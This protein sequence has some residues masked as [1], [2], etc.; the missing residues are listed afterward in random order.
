MAAR[1]NR[2]IPLLIVAFILATAAPTFAASTIYV[3]ADAPGAND[4]SSWDDAYNYLQDALANANSALKPVEIRVAEGIYTP[5]SNSANPNGSG[6]RYATFQL[7]NSVALKGGYASAGAPDPNAR[8]IELYETILTGDLNGDD[9][10]PPYLHEKHDNSYHVVT[11]SAT[12]ASAVLDGFTIYGGFAYDSSNKVE[13]GGGMLNENGSPMLKDCTFKWN[14]ASD[15]GG[16]MYNDN[17]KPTLINCKFS[18]NFAYDNNGGGM[19]N[20]KSNPTL[21]NC[22]FSGNDAYWQGGGMCNY[23]SNPTLENCTFTANDVMDVGSGMYN[24][25]SSPTLTNCIFS[26]NLAGWNGGGMRNSYSSPILTNCTFVGN[27]AYTGGGMDN[28]Y[29]T[30][31]LANCTFSGN[32]ADVSSGGMYNYKSSPTLTNCVFV[33]NSGRDC[34]GMCNTD[35]SPRLTNCVFSHNVSPAMYNSKSSDLILTNCTFAQNSGNALACDSYLQ[36]YP[37]KLVLTNCILWN[38]GDEIRNNDNS[39]ITINYSDVQGGWPGD[40]NIDADPC[41]AELGYRDVNVMPD[42]DTYHFW[43]EGDYHLMPDSPCIDAGEPNYIAGP[44]ETDLDGKPRVLDGDN[45][46]VPVV[47]MGAYESP[48]PAEARILP[49]TIN[50]ASKGNWITCYIWLPEGYDV[51]DIEPDSIFLEDEIQPEQFSV[52][53]QKQVATATF[54][55]EKVQSILN[56]GDIEL[57]ITCQLADETVFEATDTIKVIDKAGK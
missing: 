55:R 21:I 7:I 30:P 32:Y 54:D 45:D 22:L 34:G 26:G 52:N 49:Q 14:S 35:S 40:G 46:G 47:D 3:D 20:Y 25:E 51:A 36:Q 24:N 18:D 53:E 28:W 15:D 16:G 41:F 39:V 56:V 44:N 10:V 17:S 57:T 23:Q 43:V 6:D 5:D 48:I 33:D 27:D 11:G 12:D 1:T 9:S 13:H 4:G 8:H 42:G 2:I 31:I 37:S 19:Y 38:G 50:L 29:S